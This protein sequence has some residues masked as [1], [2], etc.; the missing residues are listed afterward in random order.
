MAANS[1]A[2]EDRDVASIVVEEHSVDECFF[3]QPTARDLV[4]SETNGQSER[5][6][7]DSHWQDR[8]GKGVDE[9]ADDTTTMSELN[10]DYNMLAKRLMQCEAEKK[11]LEQTVVELKCQLADCRGREDWNKL[12]M[13]KVI[14]ERDVLKRRLM[15]ELTVK[16]P[17]QPSSTPLQRIKKRFSAN[18]I[19]N[20]WK[21][22]AEAN[23]KSTRHLLEK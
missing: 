20:V 8:D 2:S 16:I 4:A 6:I 17:M 3:I 9:T 10:Y 23:N 22:A 14:F 7:Y 1:A 5:R 18:E 12:E 11:T 19:L 13:K 21:D 15:N